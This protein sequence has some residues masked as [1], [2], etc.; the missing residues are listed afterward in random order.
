MKSSPERWKNTA[1]LNLSV[2]DKRGKFI[3]IPHM[4]EAVCGIFVYE[5]I[6]NDL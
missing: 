1:F 6:M 3:K 5:R 2:S 4:A